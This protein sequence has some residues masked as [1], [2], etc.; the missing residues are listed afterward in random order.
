M[1]II[2]G[3]EFKIILSEYQDREETYEVCGD[4]K[5]LKRGLW[6]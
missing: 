6:V 1:K 3:E 4:S 5:S 2:N